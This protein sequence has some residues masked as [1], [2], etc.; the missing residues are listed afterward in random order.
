[1]AESAGHPNVIYGR[2]PTTLVPTSVLVDATSQSLYVGNWVWNSTSLVWEKQTQPGTTIIYG[3]NGTNNHNLRMDAS[4]RSLQTIDYAHHEI[5]GGSCFA[6]H[7]YDADFDG[8]EII[9]VSFTTPDTTKWLHV[10]ALVGSSTAATFEIGEGSTVTAGSG[11]AYTVINRN[12]NSDT[13]SVVSDLA[14]SPATNTVTLNG[15]ISNIGTVI[16][17]EA[18]GGGKNQAGGGGIRDTEEYILK[19]DTT[20]SF[21]LTNGSTDNGVASMQLSWYEHTHKAA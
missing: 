9:S 15:T 11:S 13:T 8:A 2:A 12:R 6:A 4:T 20:Y 17:G 19:Q 10:V 3:Y 16:H 1:M 21:R 14:A 5:H 7:V 18:L